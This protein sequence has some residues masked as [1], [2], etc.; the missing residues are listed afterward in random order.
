[1]E[2]RMMTADESVDDE[3]SEKDDVGRTRL[4]VWVGLH[5]MHQ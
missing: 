3:K 2:L 5:Q 1:M 4:F